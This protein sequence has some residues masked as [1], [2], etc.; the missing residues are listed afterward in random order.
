MNKGL[1]ELASSDEVCAYFHQVVQEVLLPSGRVQYFP[2]C[3]WIEGEREFQS[4]LTGERFEV[5]RQTRIVD[6]T[7]MKVTVPSMRPPPFQVAADVKVMTPNELVTLS[8]PYSHYTVVGSGK[9]GI[10]TCLW[11]LSMGIRPQQ[12]TWVMPRDAWLYDRAHWQDLYDDRAKEAMKR[13]VECT[14]S[15]T[16]LEDYLLRLEA[17]GMMLRLD[18]K[19]WPTS[20]RC[21]TVTLAELDEI[22]KI[23]NVVRLGRVISIDAQEIVFQHGVQ[24]TVPDTV[25]I[26][27]SANGLE[28]RPA[29]PIFTPEKITLQPVRFC[30]Q[31]FSA[32]FIGHVE[33]AYADEATRNE[34]CRPIFHPTLPSDIPIVTLSDFRATL[35]WSVEPKTVAW[36]VNSRLN[37]SSAFAP[38]ATNDPVELEQERL[39]LQALLH[40]MSE[41]LQ[42]FIREGA[43]VMAHI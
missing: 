28:K 22:R 43:R 23:N 30:Q 24:P 4:N 33:A 16:S 13:Q 1:Y 32:A 27:C 18:Q 8:R 29:V 38:L 17:A 3:E 40:S 11:L 14:L 6:A 31:V 15:A 42:Q 35:R 26:D 37:W 41:K 5:G 19:V 10:D 34:L 36:L 7:Y 20:F 12:I 25:Y 9:T 39:Q 21:A 2:K